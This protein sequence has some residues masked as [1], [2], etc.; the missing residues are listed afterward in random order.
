MI[1]ILFILWCG[2][3]FIDL[4]PPTGLSVNGTFFREVVHKGWGRTPC[5]RTPEKREELKRLYGAPHVPERSNISSIAAFGDCVATRDEGQLSEGLTRRASFAT[6]G[7]RHAALPS[8]TAWNFPAD[9]EA[10]TMRAT[11]DVRVEELLHVRT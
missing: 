8:A 3:F 5:A 11:A 2:P 7:G 9:K 4:R 6:R 1:L 10:T